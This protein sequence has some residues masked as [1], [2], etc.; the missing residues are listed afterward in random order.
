MVSKEWP[1]PIQCLFVAL[2][3]P[4]IFWLRYG[5]VDGFA[6]GFTA[7]LLLL[8]TGVYYLP[9]LSDKAAA[10]E[11]D[12]PAVKPSRWDFL[13]VFWL[14]LIPFAPLAMWLYAQLAVLTPG[15]WQT[16]LATKTA[17]CVVL[18]VICVLPLLRYA[19][20]KT[21]HVA[22]LILLLGTAYPVSVGWASMS[23]LLH[24]PEWQKVEIV[25]VRRVHCRFGCVIF[26]PRLCL[27]S[28]RM[29]GNSRRT[30]V[31]FSLFWGPQMRWC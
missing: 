30:L 22:L 18:P 14:L 26:P 11:I 24:G 13:G 19:R 10:G 29:A 15:N 17:I 1:F 8:M 23:D 4:G 27:S 5:R 28:S 3:I 9:K 20:G 6:V 31:W 25:D 7:F 12:T 2:L 16:I 21:G